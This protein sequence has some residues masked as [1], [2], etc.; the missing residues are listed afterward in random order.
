MDTSLPVFV[1]AQDFDKPGLQL[2]N[3]T[4][5][6]LGQLNSTAEKTALGE[7]DQ[8]L[9]VGA[10]AKIGG[11][12]GIVTGHLAFERQARFDKPNCR[13]KKENRLHDFLREVG[14]VVVA[15]QVSKLVQ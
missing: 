6:G 14:P 4:N 1:L 7:A 8:R 3:L 13:M 5:S 10:R 9:G 2:L 12:H 11:K 15:M